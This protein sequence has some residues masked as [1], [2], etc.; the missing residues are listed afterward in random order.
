MYRGIC[1]LAATSLR[2]EIIA[3]FQLSLKTSFNTR[4]FKVRYER[5]LLDSYSDLYLQL[6]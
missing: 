2:H 6:K 3:I 5:G 4:Q 1:Q